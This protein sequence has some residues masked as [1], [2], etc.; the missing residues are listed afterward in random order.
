MRDQANMPAGTIR[1]PLYARDGTVR[2]YTLIDAADEPLL[3]TAPWHVT[4]RGYAARWMGRKNGQGTFVRLHRLITGAPVGVEVD[5][6]N[7]DTLDNRRS[8]LRLVS[9][10]E[11]VQN[12]PRHRGGTSRYRGV[13]WD[14]ERQTWRAEVRVDG[15]KIRVGR[16]ADEAAAGDAAR[17]ARA[18]LMPF[19]T[20]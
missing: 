19:A 10:A 3:G 1:V 18:R 7:R 12:R 13:Y 8:N 20:D 2:A 14:D 5:H 15:R 9:H 4:A 6:I 16:F 11:N 17:T